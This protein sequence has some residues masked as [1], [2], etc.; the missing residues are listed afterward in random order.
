M[1]YEKIASTILSIILMSAFL[2]IFFFT[3]AAHVE[4]NIVKNQ[5][6][7]IIND[8]TEDLNSILTVNIKHF[9]NTYFAIIF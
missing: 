3:Y 1:I 5:S 7:N 8:L 4:K 6:A 2:G 9:T